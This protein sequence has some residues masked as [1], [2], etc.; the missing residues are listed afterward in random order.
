MAV[1]LSTQ[2]AALTVVF[3]GANTGVNNGADYVLPYQLIVN[4]ISIN[5]T[6]YDLFDE[7]S[8]GQNLDGQ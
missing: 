5:A 7:V 2:A 6:C 8:G 4:G 1:G 3:V